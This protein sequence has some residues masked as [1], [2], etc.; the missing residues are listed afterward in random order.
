MRFQLVVCLCLWIPVAQSFGVH[1]PEDQD[2]SGDDEFSGSGSGSGDFD[3]WFSEP[4]VTSQADP[5]TTKT[6]WITDAPV[7]LPERSVTRLAKVVTETETSD[8]VSE[9]LLPYTTQTM[10]TQPS[11][12]IDKSFGS[13]EDQ[14]GETTTI[15]TVAQTE[16]TVA[17]TETTVAQT[18]TTVAQTET[19]VAQTETTV[20]QTE[21]T[22]PPAV[23][24]PLV[25]MQ[26]DKYTTAAKDEEDTTESSVTEQVVE[27]TTVV[28]SV[29]VMTEPPDM[30]TTPLLLSI[31][32]SPSDL[33]DT[34]ASGDSVE[35]TTVQGIGEDFIET[36]IIPE[37]REHVGK[38][39]LNDNDFDFENEIQKT[40]LNSDRSGSDFARGSASDNDS[41]LE[42]K[43]VLA[44]VI[45]GGVV[46]LAFAIMLVA[47]MVYRMKKKDEGSYSLDE[48]KHPNGGYQKPQKQEEFLA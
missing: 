31:T 9:A 29:S 18:E 43:E 23:K 21:I 32:A 45:A 47:L 3:I 27:E 8:H 39:R 26:E 22:V 4:K 24:L 10:E 41:L 5:N 19:T 2:G 30:A 37:D 42:R 6:P 20:A 28:E 35:V 12:F 40:G 16:T 33:A 38:P 11:L 46:G 34:E 48:H 36:N 13:V 1:A 17:Q 25:P 15:T 14:K 7:N 44:G